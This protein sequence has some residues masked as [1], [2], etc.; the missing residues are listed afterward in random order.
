[1]FQITAA[2]TSVVLLF[3]RVTCQQEST[4]VKPDLSMHSSSSLFT[5]METTSPTHFPENSKKDHPQL[6]PHTTP[7]SSWEI[8]DSNKANVVTFDASSGKTTWT[9]PQAGRTTDRQTH[10][11]IESS[12]F[13]STERFTVNST[14]GSAVGFTER[15]TVNSTERT[16]GGPTN[17]PAGTSAYQNINI[18]T[19]QAS[20]V[21]STENV[22][23][24]SQEYSTDTSTKQPT[25]TP[26]V[27]VT[28]QPTNI[29]THNSTDYPT[30][31]QTDMMQHSSTS[32]WTTSSTQEQGDTKVVQF[33]TSSLAIESPASAI[34]PSTELATH[35]EIELS[36]ESIIVPAYTEQ[37]TKS[38]TALSY[39]EQSTEPLTASIYFTVE[40]TESV[41][42]SIYAEGSTESITASIYAEGSTESIIASIYAEGST[43]SITASIYAEGSTESITASIYAEGSTNVYTPS[44]VIGIETSAK[45]QNNSG[46]V[47]SKDEPNDDWK[48]AVGVAVPVLAAIGF[49]VGIYICYRKKY[50][51]RMIIGREF[52]KFSNPNYPSR[53]HTPSLVREDADFFFSS[54]RTSTS[55]PSREFNPVNKKIMHDNMVIVRHENDDEEE[56]ERKF[57][58]SKSWL[59]KKDSAER[60]TT[61]EEGAE[62]TAESSF[63]GSSETGAS[64]RDANRNVTRASAGASKPRAGVDERTRPVITPRRKKRAPDPPGYKADDS[65]LKVK[66][67]GQPATQHVNEQPAI[68]QVTSETRLQASKT[69]GSSL[70]RDFGRVGV[71]DKKHLKNADDNEEITRNVKAGVQL[72]PSPA[73]NPEIKER[74]KSL[75]LDTINFEGRPRSFSVDPPPR[76]ARKMTLYDEIV[77]ATRLKF[78][79]AEKMTSSISGE[80]SKVTAFVVGVDIRDRDAS[81]TSSVLSADDDTAH[82]DYITGV[83]IG[84]W[85]QN[86]PEAKSQTVLANEHSDIT[87]KWSN[88]K[89]KDFGDVHV[90]ETSATDQHDV[91]ELSADLFTS[92]RNNMSDYKVSRARQLYTDNKREEEDNG[93][94]DTPASQIRDKVEHLGMTSELS[95]SAVVKDIDYQGGTDAVLPGAYSHGNNEHSQVG[96]LERNTSSNSGRS[97]SLYDQDDTMPEPSNVV[98]ASELDKPVIKNIHSGR[99]FADVNGVGRNTIKIIPESDNGSVEQE[100]D[101]AADHLNDVN[102]DA[103]IS[104]ASERR[105]Q[106]KSVSPEMRYSGS[107]NESVVGSSESSRGIPS[108]DE[109]DEEAAVI[110]P[111]NIEINTNIITLGKD[112]LALSSA[113]GIKRPLSRLHRGDDLHNLSSP[114]PDDAENSKSARFQLQYSDS[115][116]DSSDILPVKAVNLL[117]GE[118]HNSD[119][120]V[121]TINSLKITSPNEAHIDTSSEDQTEDGSN[122]E[123]SS[124]YKLL[125]YDEDDDIDV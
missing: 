59:F 65:Q 15:F 44:S 120:G 62:A 24:S 13:P 98:P 31:W 109:H 100:N 57:L 103:S 64:R 74:S 111:T 122:V 2:I 14:A 97:S 45:P 86:K 88:A 90:H 115:S 34:N 63:I 25:D 20:K 39:T 67:T 101:A 80:D 18:T 89:Q 58:Q 95:S 123:E 46:F 83:N 96:M 73:F 87:G 116:S 37:S 66:P 4:S 38:I 118:R 49:F 33:Y 81:V 91:S 77:E 32:S 82:D 10:L 102:N 53:N 35:T 124:G 106:F 52:G 78:L 94:K 99:I 117:T 23:Q 50:P 105:R 72:F 8:P 76:S 119:F 21:E 12:M 121:E 54:N 84:R 9:T 27:N 93:S 41:T 42:A 85:E 70:P 43:E 40:I 48:I 30:Q 1:M 71:K 60:N 125:D 110:F 107:S 47:G 112:E 104:P 19:Y 69:I 16:T 108:D 51:V 5:S 79:A 28:H 68:L 113:S 92:A 36:T 114:R 22:R 56:K 26:A 29:I 11:T 61:V 75:S 6:I 55:V 7:Q 3:L 17:T